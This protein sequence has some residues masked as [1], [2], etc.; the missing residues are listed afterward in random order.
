[1]KRL[2]VIVLFGTRPEAIKLAPVIL[3]LRS[4][5]DAFECVVVFSG[6]HREMG[7]ATLA[8]FGLVPDRELE[9]MI[10]GQSLNRLASG[11]F[12]GLDLLIGS[13]RPDWVLVQGDTTTAMVGALSAFFAKVRV[14]HVEAGLR[15]LD[16]FSP[17]P[18]EVNR[19]VVGRVADLHFAPTERAA[20]ALRSEG[21]DPESV[22]L[23][24][25][26][27]VDA[28][29]WMRDRLPPEPPAAL[30]AFTAAAVRVVLVTCHRRESFGA[31]MERVCVAVARLAARFPDVRFVLPVHPNPEARRTVEAA[32]TSVPGVLLTEPLDYPDLL[33]CIGRS[34]LILSDSGGIQEEAPSFG[35][36]LLV[37]R[38][39]TERPEVAESGAGILVG[40]D[41][42]RIVS[43]AA[44]FLG[45]VAPP[46]D[47]AVVVNPFGDGRAAVRIADGI[48]AFPHPV[49]R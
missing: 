18:E 13:E 35:K 15:T 25:N 47:R 29:H 45:E 17:F 12:A 22:L 9:T 2:K 31:P 30:G 16:R 14:G 21:V 42:D 4:R 6:Q 37:L 33:W 7:R 49:A 19:Q 41:P 48:L 46:G 11:L 39:K 1:M 10:P 27:V 38:E 32:L 24:G 28:L 8:T 34:T 44:R 36:P 26:P 40:T 3:E 20:A 23:T 5:P 43:E